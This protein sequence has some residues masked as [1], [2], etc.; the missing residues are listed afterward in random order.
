[1]SVPDEEFDVL[2]EDDLALQTRRFER[3]HENRVNM[4]RNKRACF[5]CG[6]LGHFVADYPEK[7][8]NK[9]NYKHKSKTNGKYRSRCDYKHKH[10]CE[11]KDERRSRKK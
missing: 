5:Q 7:V 11:R 9:D 3:L 8:E 4:R 10:R 1:M 6:K 2:G